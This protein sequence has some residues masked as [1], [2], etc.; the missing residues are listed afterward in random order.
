[1]FME[2]AVHTQLTEEDTHALNKLEKGAP[3]KAL[4]ERRLE[5]LPDEGKDADAAN[6]VRD[7]G[8]VD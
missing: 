1:M 6:A 8:H 3:T 4:D 5:R 7:L 2:H